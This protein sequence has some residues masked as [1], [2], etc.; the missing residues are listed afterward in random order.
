MANEFVSLQLDE[1]RPGGLVCRVQRVA[2]DYTHQHDVGGKSARWSE[3]GSA[4][5]FFG[6]TA[7]G[8]PS[9]YLLERINTLLMMS[10]LRWLNTQ[11][12]TRS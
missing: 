5:T 12:E 10:F 6:R 2:P 8:S 1:L 3:V 11:A 4:G 9:I 7:V